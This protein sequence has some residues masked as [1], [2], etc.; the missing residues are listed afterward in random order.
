MVVIA[1]INRLDDKKIL[2]VNIHNAIV[3]P[4]TFGLPS[5]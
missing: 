5:L 2:L 3:R 4:L 1:V